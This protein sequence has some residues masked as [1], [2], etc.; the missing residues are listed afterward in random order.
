[1]TD[2]MGW[3][4]DSWSQLGETIARS[5]LIFLAAVVLLRMARRRTVAQWTV[6]DVVTAVS[7]GS[8][9]G[10]TATAD[11]ESVLTGLV[12]LVTL[13]ALHALVIEAR[14]L[15]G[16]RR[17]T[18][19]RVR[20]LVAE[21]QVRHRELR[22]CGLTPAD[23]EERLRLQGVRDLGEV[24][25]VLFERQGGLTVVGRDDTA[26]APLVASA[27]DDAAGWSPQPRTR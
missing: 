10:R 5:A 26:Q 25:Y 23:L 9:V 15:P 18:D 11:S 7:I 3:L 16:V 20:V 8:V 2:G 21:E 14:R 13:V 4:T 6:V 17:V 12:A 22:R 24:R 1:M 27:L 19:H